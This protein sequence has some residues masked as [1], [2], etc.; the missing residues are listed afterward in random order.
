MVKQAGPG[1]PPWWCGP[2]TGGPVPEPVSPQRLWRP[3]G[4]WV[5]QDGVVQHPVD[6]V[7]PAPLLGEGVET[8]SV[9][10]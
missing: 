2:G 1:P 3:M 7:P 5:L 4:G 9:Q 10:T 8:Q 6:G